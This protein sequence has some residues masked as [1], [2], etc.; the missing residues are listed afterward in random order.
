M[1]LPAYPRLNLPTKRLGVESGDWIWVSGSIFPG[2]LFKSFALFAGFFF[3]AYFYASKIKP[4]RP[5]GWAAAWIEFAFSPRLFIARLEP[6][7]GPNL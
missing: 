1:G 6:I 2:L 7:G 3:L 5:K 4:R